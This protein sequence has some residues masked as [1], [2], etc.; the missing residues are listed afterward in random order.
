[1]SL[2]LPTFDDIT[3]A[4]VRLKG[5][6]KKTPV[7][8]S[9]MLDDLAGAKVLVKAE[10]LQVTGSFKI[11][12]AYNRLAQLSGEECKT[13]VVAF[14]S[15]N[16]AQG[17][18]RAAKL[19][20]MP[21]LIVMPSDAPAIKREGVRRDG[22]E[23]HLYDRETES[24]EDIAAGIAAERGAV[25]VPSF[26]DPHIIAGQGTTG[27]EFFEQLDVPLDHLICCAGGGGLISGIAL[28][29]EQLSPTTKIWTAE[30]A[31]HDD[32]KRSLEAGAIVANVPGTRS[33]CDA[34]LT[35]QPGELPWAIGQRLLSG[36]FALS[37]TEIIN[38]ICVA[39]AA[40]GLTLEP[41][42]AAAL[43]VAA[44][45]LPAEMCGARVG[46]I[47]TGGNVDPADYAAYING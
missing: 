46:I 27:L 20:A 10:C 29:L 19:L 31:T 9:P 7:L 25:L 8:T 42:G 12:G 13:G 33:I 30:P 38:G 22:A 5:V 3:Q 34:I 23:I 44:R 16:H 6:A 47:A 40:F 15:G 2:L 4:A 43:S 21:A 17:I 32:W 35:P 41:G 11:R 45:G 18:A 36:G 1:M 24:R 37:D 14:S 26:D 39:K 28:A